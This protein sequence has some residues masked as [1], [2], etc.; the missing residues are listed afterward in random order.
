MGSAYELDADKIK[1][2]DNVD[3][4]SVR[5]KI[6]NNLVNSAQKQR[7]TDLLIKQEG[8]IKNSFHYKFNNIKL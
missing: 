5:S 8:H 7:A 1:A 2:A 4:I 6:A 3:S